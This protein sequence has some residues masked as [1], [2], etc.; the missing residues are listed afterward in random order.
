MRPVLTELGWTSALEEAFTE[1]VQQAPGRA[2]SCGRIVRQESLVRVQ[3]ED[4]TVLAKPSK[5]LLRAAETGAELPVV[6]D[7]VTVT[8]PADDGIA[9]IQHVLP[10]RSVLM[11]REAGYERNA[12]AI[13]AN[14]DEVFLLNGLDTKINPRRIER[15]LALTLAS[16]AGAVIALSKA[17]LAS[18]VDH[19]VAQVRAIA[20]DTPI[21]VLSA[22]EPSGQGVDEIVRR[23]GP[24]RTGVL[25]GPSG[26]GKST[27]ANRL[28]GEARLATSEVRED[29][30]EGRHT[31]THRELFRLPGGGMLIDGPGMREFGLWTDDSGVAAVFEDIEALA[32]QCRFR[33]CAHLQEPGCAV[34]HALQTG[35]LERSR[36]E[37]WRKLQTE[38]AYQQRVAD[39][40]RRGPKP[41]GAHGFERVRH[42]KK[43][44]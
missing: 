9:L 16:G 1:L 3:L 24:G 10:R 18:D 13:A 42:D 33:D 12:Q 43:R 40:S 21:V 38:Q 27:L 29:D 37:S 34:Q 22:K 5:K 26:V 23:L 20:G 35:A 25:I 31:T 7:F 2:L 32:Q 41:R 28:I 19:A 8:A 36:Y 11:R 6:G 15:M 44:S 4:R 17:D 39:P 30:R 14:V